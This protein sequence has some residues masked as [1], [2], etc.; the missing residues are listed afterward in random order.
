MDLEGTDL[1][2]HSKLSASR[3]ELP[4]CYNFINLS[5]LPQTMSANLS[6]ANPDLTQ[7]LAAL[8]GAKR[9]LLELQLM[10]KNQR[11]EKM[12]QAI[13][14]RRLK[15]SPLSYS[16]QG[17]WVL[18]QLMPGESVYH[19]PTAAR[20][21]GTLDVPA[22][23]QA[24]QAIV[25]RHDSLRTIF[26]VVDGEP[27]QVVEDLTLEAPVIDLST[28]IDENR[29]DAEALRILEHDARR[30]F[31]LSTGPLIRAI[32]VRLRPDEHILL[33]T[34]HHVVTD[35]WSIGLFHR[36]LSSLYKA[37][38]SHSPS[39]LPDLPIQYIDYAMYQR[40]WFEGKV[41]ESQLA[42]W[43]K[44]FATMP[45]A[46]ELP[47]D[48][49]RPIVQA[50][51]AFRG[52]QHTM[53]L[54]ADL[55]RRIRTLCQRENVTLF[56]VLMAA[57]QILLHRYTG[58]EDIVVGSPIAGRSLAE[59]ED[60]IGLFIN[61][62][63]IRSRV[64]GDATVRDFLNHV[65]QVALGAYAHQDLPFERLVKELQ[66]DRT[67]SHNPLFQ[68]M[69]VLQ[70]EEILP[71]NLPGVTAE[72]FRIDHVIANFDLT[73]DIT[74]HGDELACMFE[75]NAD[76]FDPE[77]ITRLMGHFQVLLEGMT[78]NPGLKV[79]ELPLLTEDERQQLLY[80][81]NKTRADSTNAASIQEMFERQAGAS[82]DAV[83]LFCDGVQLTYR[84][85]NERANQLAHCLRERGVGRDTMVGM[86]LH[87][88]PNLMIALLGILKAGGAYVPLD[89]AYP[90]G[91]L[92][93]MLQD[94]G[95]PLLVTEKSLADKI[96]AAAGAIICIDEIA[97]E[98][99]KRST[100][101]PESITQPED[102][103]YVIYTSG[104]T[105]KPKGVLVP[106]RSVVNLLA[107]VAK[108][109][110][111]T[112]DD[113]VL[114]ITTVSFDI[115]VSEV[116]LPLTVGAKMVL[117]SRETASDGARLLRTIHDQ[118]VTFI[119]ATPATWRLLLA[120]GW[121]GT[122][123][124][125]AIC[126]GE[127]MPLDLAQSLTGR[128]ARVWNGY[129]PTETT[130]WSSFYEV[131]ANI[132]RVLIGR[133]VA[134]TAAYV[135]DSNC[136]PVPIG[137]SGELFIGGECVT[138]GYHQRPELTADR[139]LSDPFR[140]GGRM[141]KSGD[142]VRYLP[143]GNIECLGRNDNQV[144]LRGYRIE[145][146]EIETALTEH[147]AV[148]QA[149]VVSQTQHEDQRLVA[150][151]VPRNGDLVH[152]EVREFLQTRLPDYMVPLLFMTVPS[153]PLSPAGKVDR[154]ALPAPDDFKR[155]ADRG[156]VAAADELELKLTRIWERV[157]KV[158]PIGVNENFFELGGHSLLA[159][160]LFV[161]VEKSFGKNLPLAT[162]FQAPT[163]AQLARV[164][165][166]EGWQGAWS[167]LV[168]IQ[169]GGARTPFFCMHSVGGNV[170]EYHEL[171]RLLGPGQP[172]YGLQAKGLDGKSEPHTSIK[173]MAAHYLK[174]MREI[175][176]AGPYLLGGRSSGGTIAF[177]MACQLEAAGETV[178]LLALFDTF[179][180]GYFKLLQLSFGRRLARRARRWQSH[181]IN[182]GSL[183]AADKARYVAT[184]LRFAPEKAKH[185][186]YRRAY[187]L[188]KKFGKP[189][190]S[191]LQNIEEINFAAVKDYQP[192]I[193]A[194][195]VTLFL[196][197]DLTADYDSKDG[198]RELVKG[199]IETH[200][201]P[202]N[203]LNIIKE[204]GVRTLAEKL[205]ATIDQ[206]GQ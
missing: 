193:Y 205:R 188:Y 44:Q 187:K 110:G 27:M 69:F 29:R 4:A 20:L 1:P 180:S 173:E 161:E 17:L 191:V 150:Y 179:P 170:L 51:R 6:A 41:Y 98:L 15:S 132:K 2:A 129:G 156:F 78:Q 117:V 62:L 90:E 74:E 39:P 196:A 30:P 163:V 169:T 166:D 125:T 99:S 14:P 114:A 178:A 127:A 105:G 93:F 108:T 72:H 32:I 13:R 65:K 53:T 75:S 48:H 71:L 146:G 19:S 96:P 143:D 185:R 3:L 85:L 91:R 183:N 113:V 35:G 63:A 45:P 133:P 120:A 81:W 138:R 100:A 149:V 190:P 55:A 152:S 37:F 155:E 49:P 145:L 88:S 192:Q 73:L 118:K 50:Y 194:G 162:L 86:C 153:L 174:E 147:H 12:R 175:Q 76:L 115:A 198:W 64:S 154:R 87:R 21:R 26:S 119:D 25:D 140:P 131:P 139:F 54:S 176:P 201:V 28:M 189:L 168:P 104:S 103:A 172:F 200:E 203:H 40:E 171:A 135:L 202:G 8:T 181:L 101:N 10:K 122:P 97:P 92:E 160:K 84:E 112:S 141:Y 199:R 11:A 195:D 56:M 80:D 148:H 46:L 107:S 151:L 128:A 82:P 89:P 144:K 184:K 31:E 70:S 66:P 94:S 157:L 43:K 24:L 121:E 197:T 9:V 136:Q 116:I 167:S 130:V 5:S 57:Y 123:G 18:N 61:T 77:T 158:S 38:A 59:T 159:V 164:L 68:V 33:V 36:E 109:P 206:L 186:I 42:Y 58:E 22:L 52:N 47:A 177:E 79:S 7:Q 23:Q 34:M 137:V 165:R 142:V 60:L 124:L 83:A 182:L 102:L 106:H 111:V 126:T 134:N 204:P 67:L 95:A 16:Q